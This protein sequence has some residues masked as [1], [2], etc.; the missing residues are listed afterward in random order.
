MLCVLRQRAVKR[1]DIFNLCFC[2]SYQVI[3]WD[4]QTVLMEKN[5]ELGDQRCAVSGLRLQGLDGPSRVCWCSSGE[6]LIT[7]DGDECA[8][9]DVSN[10]SGLSGHVKEKS[11]AMILSGLDSQIFGVCSHPCLG[12]AVRL[13]YYCRTNDNALLDDYH[14]LFLLLSVIRK[15]AAGHPRDDNA[16]PFQD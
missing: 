6:Q 12:I 15:I 7:F 14:Y 2:I 4:I 5:T 13:L 1:Y 16:I 9:W 11:D 3:C 10:C 8:L